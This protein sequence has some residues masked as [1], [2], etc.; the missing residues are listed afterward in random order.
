MRD[1]KESSGN[2]QEVLY[3]LLKLGFVDSS[4]SC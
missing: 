2:E 3:Q 4:T 1:S